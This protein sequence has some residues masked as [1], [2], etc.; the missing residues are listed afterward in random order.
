MVK[1][2]KYQRIGRTSNLP[3]SSTFFN[4]K[5]HFIKMDVIFTYNIGLMGDLIKGLSGSL[6]LNGICRNF[7]ALKLP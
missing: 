4:S 1:A 7:S 5:E 2:G 6:A 3:S